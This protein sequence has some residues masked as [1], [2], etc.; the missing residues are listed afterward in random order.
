MLEE[1]QIDEKMFMST[2]YLLKIHLNLF[3]ISNWVL[4]FEN[5]IQMY[6]VWKCISNVD[7]QTVAISW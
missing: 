6:P 7:L 1:Y 3:E 4:K 2:I 5:L